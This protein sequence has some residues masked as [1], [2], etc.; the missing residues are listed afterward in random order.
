VE[1]TRD[2]EG[3]PVIYV[4]PVGRERAAVITRVWGPQCINV[5]FVNMDEGQEDSYGRKIERA[6]SCMHRTIQ[7][8]HGNYW[9]LPDDPERNPVSSI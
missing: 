9:K 3:R 1:A 5:A 6:T 2:W 7:Q 4:D 8:A